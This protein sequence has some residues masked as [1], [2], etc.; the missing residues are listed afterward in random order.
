[1]LR[2]ALRTNCSC[3][4]DH[5]TS[6]LVDARDDSDAT[7][8]TYQAFNV[9]LFY[10]FIRFYYCRHFDKLY[11][12]MLTL[13]TL[14]CCTIGCFITVVFVFGSVDVDNN[15]QQ[16]GRASAS[17]HTNNNVVVVAFVAWV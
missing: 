7:S 6:Y 15:N 11:N 9:D 5:T 2:I 1:M 4:D 17:T 3:T 12:S 8:N 10:S 16:E 14:L 13:E